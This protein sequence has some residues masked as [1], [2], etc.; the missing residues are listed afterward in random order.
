MEVQQTSINQE[1]IQTYCQSPHIDW[2][3]INEV[4]S[5]HYLHQKGHP[6]KTKRSLFS[7]SFFYANICFS[8]KQS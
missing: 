2:Q 6:T 1:S 5:N 4:V 8:W 7:A 3:N